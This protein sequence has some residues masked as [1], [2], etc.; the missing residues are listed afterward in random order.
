MDW[1]NRTGREALAQTCLSLADL[2]DTLTPDQ[3]SL[4]TGCPGWTVF[5]Q[6]AHVSSLESVMA[7]VPQ[8]AHEAPPAAYVRNSIGTAMENLVDARRGWPPE[9]VVAELREA[10]RLRHEQL[11][12]LDEDPE[13]IGY[14]PTGK[15]MP[16]ADHLKL[17]LFDCVAHEQDVRRAV[18]RP[19][20]LD[21]TAAEIVAANIAELL[22]RAWG[23]LERTSATVTV[24]VEG[25]R[26]VVRVGDGGQPVELTLSVADLIMLAG[27]RSDADVTAVTVTGDG[28]TG[29][30]LVAAMGLTP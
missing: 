29:R 23:R 11:S 15:P 5:D 22:P 6:V 2:A 3:W 4:P 19:G 1:S 14:G 26:S 10:I 27:G 12:A 18:G 17:R 16:L 24:D 8:P 21:G 9:K 25:R 13:A 20:G 30:R 28:E 7:G